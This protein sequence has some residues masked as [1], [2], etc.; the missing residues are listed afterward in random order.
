LI[1]L[2]LH[3]FAGAKGPDYFNDH[4]RPMISALAG[5]I[6]EC[7]PEDLYLAENV[8]DSSTTTHGQWD[9]SMLP[10]CAHTSPYLGGPQRYL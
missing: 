7:H 6:N 2:L 3:I 8:I 10:L 9:Q 1:D 4:C 5:E